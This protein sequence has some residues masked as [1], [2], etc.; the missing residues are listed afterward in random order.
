MRNFLTLLVTLALVATFTPVDATVREI[1]WPTPADQS[2]PCP[3]EGDDAPLGYKG[4]CH[5][6]VDDVERTLWQETNGWAGLQKRPFMFQNKSIPA[7][8]Q[9][10]S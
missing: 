2:I 7:D 1:T 8:R 6:Y 5:F 10:L 9:M 3:F 4:P